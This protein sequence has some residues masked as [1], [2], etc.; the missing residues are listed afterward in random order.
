MKFARNL[1]IRGKLVLAFSLIILLSIALSAGALWRIYSA[2]RGADAL[3]VQLLQ[4]NSK[5]NTVLGAL[6]AADGAALTFLSGDGSSKTE[7]MTAFGAFNT[8]KFKAGD[9]D[10]STAGGQAAKKVTAVK[11]NALALS[12][13]FAQKIAPLMK[14][15]E[16]EQARLLFLQQGGPLSQKISSDCQALN[17][18]ALAEAEVYAN[19]LRDMRVFYFIAACTALQ[20]CLTAVIALFLSNYILRR[21]SG[22][23][24]IT[25]A[26]ASGDLGFVIRT[27][28]HGDEFDKLTRSLNTMQEQLR[29]AVSAVRSQAELLLT[30]M[31]A[32]N[33]GSQQISQS[34]NSTLEQ[35]TQVLSAAAE[36]SAVTR[37]IAS[38]CSE[39]ATASDRS[40]DLTRSSQQAV[41][42]AI[43][44]INAHNEEINADAKS[45]SELAERSK[46]VALIVKSIE[47][48][49]SKTNLLA[50]N[51]AIEAARAGEAGRGFAVVADEVRALSGMTAKSTSQ[52]AE[53]TGALKQDTE[54]N[55]QKLQRTVAKINEAS[56]DAQQV[57]EVLEQID[58]QVSAIDGQIKEIAQAAEEQSKAAQEIE[59]SMQLLE[60]NS[61]QSA[62]LAQSSAETA[63]QAAARVQELLQAL[64]VFSLPQVTTPASVDQDETTAPA[65]ATIAGK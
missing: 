43:N 49:S 31:S 59:D 22:Q 54:Q 63:K 45:L 65:T 41:S 25:S 27:C 36:M 14:S 53:V 60:Q 2:S 58:L 50:L 29:T 52:I 37:S 17:K 6:S 30:D 9:L 8:L 20:L 16:V 10:A 34:I 57:N 11:E 3:Y 32:V 18:L 15:G 23:I 38:S 12:A 7:R 35:S 55:A 62:S 21:L 56:Q 5:I 1:N 64:S 51:A 44:A 13:L 40:A 42:A 46:N 24:K 26:I 4:E 47:D 48:I 39:A 28:P 33:S 61:H 19:D